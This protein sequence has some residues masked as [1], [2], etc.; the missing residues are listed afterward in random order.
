MNGMAKKGAP[1][2][3]KKFYLPRRPRKQEAVA[4]WPPCRYG[5]QRPAGIVHMAT[6][7]FDPEAGMAFSVVSSRTLPDPAHHRPYQAL[8]RQ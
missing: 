8:P 2:D 1:M 3:F 4:F 6:G 5:D 7:N